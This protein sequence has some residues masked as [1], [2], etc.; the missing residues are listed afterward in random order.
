MNEILQ[1]IVELLACAGYL[2]QKIFLWAAERAQDL[3]DAVMER[4]WRIAAWSVYIVG[5]LP[6]VYIFITQRNWIAGLVEASG[7]PAMVL[8]LAIAI[9]GIKE[10]LPPWVFKLAI[11][12]AGCGFLVSLWDFKG[13]NTINQW[14]EIGLVLGYLVGTYQLALKKASGYI[15]YVLM[16]LCCGR[17]MWIQHS[18]WLCLQQ[19]LSLVFIA[20]AYRR[21]RQR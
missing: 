10:Q 14:L 17:L 13:I 4:R 20:A 18:P 19:V 7:L 16:H 2:F 3:K 6:W 12:S 21:V 11:V 9:R 5:L 8:G 15:W 1:L